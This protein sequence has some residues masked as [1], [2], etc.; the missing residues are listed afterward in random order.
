MTSSSILWDGPNRAWQHRSR[1]GLSSGGFGLGAKKRSMFPR[2][3]DKMVVG[4]ESRVGRWA[5]LK[6]LLGEIAA[7]H[8]SA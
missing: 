3:R 6:F 1:G 2:P 7:C 5:G 4:V 8:R